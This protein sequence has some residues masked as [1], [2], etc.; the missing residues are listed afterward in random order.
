MSLENVW[1][2]SVP[3]QGS[4]KLVSGVFTSSLVRLLKKPPTKRKI[5]KPQGCAK[6]HF[7]SSATAVTSSSLCLHE[8]N[9]KLWE[10]ATCPLIRTMSITMEIFQ[11]I[12]WILAPKILCHVGK[13]NKRHPYGKEDAKMWLFTDGLILYIENPGE[14]TKQPLVYCY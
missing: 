13:G 10:L 4:F 1:H 5:K 14:P 8:A 7:Y 6:W 2:L 11:D 12:R 9:V 3:A